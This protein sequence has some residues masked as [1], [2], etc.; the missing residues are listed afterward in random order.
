M[1]SINFFKNIICE[2]YFS[3][4]VKNSIETLSRILK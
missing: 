3:L 1:I 4:E 2:N